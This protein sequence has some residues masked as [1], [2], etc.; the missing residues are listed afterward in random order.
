MKPDLNGV[1]HSLRLVIF[2]KKDN[3]DDECYPLKNGDNLKEA[4]YLARQRADALTALDVL[5]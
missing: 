5:Y 4:A 2:L 3:S 1:I